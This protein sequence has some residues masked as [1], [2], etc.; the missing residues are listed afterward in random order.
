VRAGRGRGG[1][2]VR[3]LRWT[4]GRPGGRGK[5]EELGMELLESRGVGVCRA[6]ICVERA[7]SRA[8]R[9]RRRT[10]LF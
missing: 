4:R 3:L 6:C 1:A 2:A 8:R 5:R 9:K 7:T 10:N